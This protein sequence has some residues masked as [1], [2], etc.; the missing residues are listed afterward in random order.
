MLAC[1]NIY[2]GSIMHV[3]LSFLHSVH[4]QMVM[5]DLKAVVY[6]LGLASAMSVGWT[7]LRYMT[8]PQT[9]SPGQR[10]GSLYTFTITTTTSEILAPHHTTTHHTNKSSLYYNTM[11]SLST[12]TAIPSRQTQTLHSYSVSS[13][14]R[15]AKPSEQLESGSEA[16]TGGSEAITGGS[17]A[18]TGGSEAITGGSEV[19]SSGSEAITGGAIK[20]SSVVRPDITIKNT[21]AVS[22]GVTASPSYQKQIHSK[23]FVLALDYWEQQTSSLVSLMSLQCWAGQLKANMSVVQPF[24]YKGWPK[25]H[26][27]YHHSGS[28]EFSDLFDLTMWN[29]VSAHYNTPLVPWTYSLLLSLRRNLIT[30]EIIYWWKMSAVA[31]QN[32]TQDERIISGCSWKLEDDDPIFKSFRIVRRVCINFSFGDRLTLEEFNHLIFGTHS[33]SDVSLVFY[34][35][36]GVSSELFRIAIGGECTQIQQSLAPLTVHSSPKITKLAK[37]YIHRYMHDDKYIAVMVRI[38]KFLKHHPAVHLAAFLDNVVNATTHLSTKSGIN[39]LFMAIDIGR[40]GSSTLNVTSIQPL[41]LDFFYR[42]VGQTISFDDWERSFE[43]TAHTRDPALVA[44]VQATVVAHST[45]AVFAGGGKFQLH[46]KFMYEGLH[47][48]QSSCFVD[49]Q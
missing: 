8:S 34:Q 44:R 41:A 31:P 42:M 46:A 13:S 26:S 45:C 35:W 2:N 9:R 38:E 25:T 36:R 32:L 3:V 4:I 21:I 20:D 10:H 27:S 43:I 29:K 15:D 16:I 47:D 22:P 33:P 28:V 17:E 49:V 40:F 11:K 48:K 19:I 12:N 14:H 18:I 6:L 7:Y 24:Y 23:G 30:A 39:A 1:N 5:I 37:N